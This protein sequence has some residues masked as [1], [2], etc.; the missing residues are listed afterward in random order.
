MH[1]KVR[2]RK[3]IESQN[4]TNLNFCAKKTRFRGFHGYQIDESSDD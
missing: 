1:F 2:R 4:K 3:R